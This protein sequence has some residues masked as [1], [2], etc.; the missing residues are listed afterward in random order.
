M[1]K[2]NAYASF[3]PGN[4]VFSMMKINGRFSSTEIDRLNEI[5]FQKGLTVL[6]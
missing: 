3:D 5:T 1:V 6:E 4:F 2:N